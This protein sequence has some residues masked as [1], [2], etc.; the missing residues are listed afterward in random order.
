MG[1]STW[2]ATARKRLDSKML[3]LKDSNVP[4]PSNSS[5]LLSI[6]KL[7]Y[8]IIR[9]LHPNLH[10]VEKNEDNCLGLVMGSRTNFNYEEYIHWIE[11]SQQEGDE[12]T[13]RLAQVWFFYK[14][15][16]ILTSFCEDEKRHSEGGNDQGRLQRGYDKLVSIVGKGLLRRRKF[17]VGGLVDG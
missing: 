6:E 8:F 17:I 11:L 9:A 10:D 1:P 4:P 13:R 14:M 3:S 12:P 15:A 2:T 16:D 5:L 7:R